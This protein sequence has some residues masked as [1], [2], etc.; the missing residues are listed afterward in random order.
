M[1]YYRR[2]DKHGTDH[3]YEAQLADLNKAI[4]LDPDLADAFKDRASLYAHNLPKSRGGHA[5]AVT[6][7]TRYL[8]LKPRDAS[9]RHNRALYYE[10]LGQ[11]D[12]AI[13]DYT[14]VIEGNL[15]F[16]QQLEG[17][18]K[19]IALDCLYRG[20]IYQWR[21][22]DYTKAI[23]DYT[24]ALALDP[25]MEGAHRLRGQCYELLGDAEKAQFD[26]AIEPKR[27]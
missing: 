23:S 3:E 24:A 17:K 9:I 16:E 10:Q 25:Q 19:L 7:Y 4:E 13:T 14:L 26:F 15:D 27:N 12:N 18:N 21:K 1:E 8:E 2:A 22:H 6:D 20:R 11:S 5:Q